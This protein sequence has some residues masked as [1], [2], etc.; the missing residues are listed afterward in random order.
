M[1]KD[2]AVNV[3]VMA[4]AMH[5][6][7]DSVPPPE[8]L[9][10]E[11]MTAYRAKLMQAQS[12]GIAEGVN[13]IIG[14]ILEASKQLS[15]SAAGEATS[16]GALLAVL[17]NQITTSQLH[18][19]L[20]ARINL[21]D[22]PVTGLTVKLA[23]EIFDR[24][25][26]V[27]GEAT[28]RTT[29]LTNYYTKTAADAATA[30]AITGAEATFSGTV[31][32]ALSNYY[33]KAAADTATATAI[34]G[35]TA[36]FISGASLATS[37]ASYYTKAA[38]DTAISTAMT[39]AISTA[40]TNTATALASYSTT[41]TINGILSAEIMLK[42]DVNGKVAGIGLWNDGA[43]SAFE[44]FSD[45]F[46]IVQP[47]TTTSTVPFIVSGGVT[48]IKK[49]M[50]KDADIDT[51]KIAGSAVTVPLTATSADIAG[52]NESGPVPRLSISFVN[53]VAGTS[54]LIFVS[55]FHLY[56]SGMKNTWFDIQIGDGTTWTTIWDSGL[57]T[58]SVYL[59]SIAT[60]TDGLPIG[61]YSITFRW[62]ADSSV[63]LKNLSLGVLAAK[64]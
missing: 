13:A 14:P 10:D 6:A 52:A 26:A 47:G 4:E 2:I 3:G 51:L 48:Y 1:G 56:P 53:P 35:A 7:L 20:S 17:E 44:V 11:E 31:A 36:G 24:N 60:A 30:A 46:A 38:A 37:L 59:L 12:A 45:K 40:G 29:A 49:V 28:A 54:L 16:A 22:D 18:S 61:T 5:T 63:T 39:A 21:V 64:R 42:T 8:V 25:L 23:T 58:P 43:T 55:G 27:T 33:T 57:V 9:T 50:I 15:V 34:T 19:D 32:S 41:A 62:A